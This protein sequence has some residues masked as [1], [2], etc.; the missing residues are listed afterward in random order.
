MENE[1]Q[2]SIGFNSLLR[3]SISIVNSPDDIVFACGNTLILENLTTK[4]QSFLRGH[5]SKVSCFVL[6]KCG[7][8][9]ASAEHSQNGFLSEII[10]WNLEK[11]EQIQSLKMHKG[12]VK[13]MAFSR[14]GSYLA[15]AG[16]NEDK[17]R[18]LI[19]DLK[20]F[21]AIYAHSFGICEIN[22]FRFFNNN[23]NNIVAISDGNIQILTLNAKDK[24]IDTLVCNIGNLKR[25]FVCAVIDMEDKYIYT[26][27][28]TG[29][30]IEILVEKG[31]MK[32]VGPTGKLFDNGVKKIELVMKQKQ[33][34]QIVVGTGSGLIITIERETMK[35]SSEAQLEGSITAFCLTEGHKQA[36][37]GTEKGNIYQ[38]DLS[39]VEKKETGMPQMGFSLKESVHVGKINAICFPKNFSEVFA[40]CGNE[41]IKIWALKKRQELLRI[42]VSGVEC[43]CVYFSED[44]KMIVSGWSDGKI[45]SFFPQS[46]KLMWTI[47]D[48]HANGV[49][50]IAMTSDG[51]TLITGGQEGEIRIWKIN[52]NSRTLSASLKEHRGR[53]SS[54]HLTAA[55]ELVSCSTDGSCIIWDL[56]SQSR[57]LCIF[58]KT[59]F[60]QSRF[61]PDGSQLL[62]VGSDTKIAYWS[63]FD[64]ELIR[65][66]QGSDQ[67]G[68]INA[69]DISNEGNFLISGGQDSILRVWT[70]NEG[71]CIAKLTGNFGNIIDAKISPDNKNVISVGA[72]GELII[73]RLSDSLKTIK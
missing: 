45:R 38:V 23:E 70:Y 20:T 30:V 60:K 41:Q 73:F 46:G 52:K 71:R 6:S 19:W 34:S 64:G 50:A 67:E 54:M 39:K 56:K 16:G 28:K 12:T 51:E 55:N 37:C 4:T 7:K 69:L 72:E 5:R 8:L 31:I 24:R 3:N 47:E 49:T 11:K 2:T 9:L 58:E 21:K 63:A 33:E 65:Y 44:G 14:E 35:R 15:T 25:Q 36:I 66:V 32:R 40:C 18:L 1:I 43:H 13:Y 57:C 10:L 27:T 29:D 53:V 62:T 22:E 17:N 61:C 68:E 48:A 42:V 59:I 26:G